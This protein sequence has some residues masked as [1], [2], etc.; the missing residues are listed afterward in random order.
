MAAGAADV[1]AVFYYLALRYTRIFPEIFAMIPMTA[2][3]EH[4]PGQERSRVHAGMIG[5]GGE[6]GARLLEFMGGPQVAEIYRH[7]GLV[8]A[9]PP[10][11]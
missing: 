2:E 7:H 8:S 6:W 10:L 5:D 9:D 3:G 1:A 11:T 4:D